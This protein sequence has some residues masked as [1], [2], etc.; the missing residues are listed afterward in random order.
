MNIVFDLSREFRCLISV[1]H[2]SL[3]IE[4]CL[5]NCSC[6]SVRHGVTWIRTHQ[7]RAPRFCVIC[8]ST[9]EWLSRYGRQATQGMLC[10]AHIKSNSRAKNLVYQS[11]VYRVYDAM[12]ALL[13]SRL[14]TMLYSHRSILIAA[15]LLMETLMLSILGWCMPR[16][17]LFLSHHHHVV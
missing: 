4:A 7:A 17:V 13:F 8:H 16:I 2:D 5:H 10:S 11:C 1:S 14:F 6:R 12:C 9:E 3:D 15:I